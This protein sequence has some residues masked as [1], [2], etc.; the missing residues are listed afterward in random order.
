MTNKLTQPKVT[1]YIS[2]LG[3]NDHHGMYGCVYD[4]ESE[5]LLDELFALLEQIA[6]V[7]ENGTKTLWLRAERGPIEDFGDAEELIREGDYD[8][9]EQFI[10]SWK[11]NYPDEIEWYQFSAVELK[12]E[13]YRAVTLQ[14]RFVIVQDKHR[15]PAGFPNVIPDFVQWLIDGVKERI[16]ML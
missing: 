9:K 11:I 13:G 10:E 4:Y 16:Q 7:S 5:K 2:W 1:R 12:D 8:S 6:P 14:H 3:S 15:E